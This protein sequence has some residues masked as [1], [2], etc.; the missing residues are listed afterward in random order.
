MRKVTV[1]AAVALGIGVVGAVAI[2]TRSQ[3]APRTARPNTVELDVVFSPFTPIATNNERDRDSLIALGDE[4]V[5]HD[6]LFNDGMHTGDQAGVCVIVATAPDV[7]AS[8][9]I[10]IRLPDGQLTGQF[11]NSPGPAPKTIAITGGTGDYRHT[12]GEGTLV[13]FGNGKGHLALHVEPAGD[14][15]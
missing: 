2:G 14:R 9:S 3:A 6:E 5:F 7:L 4:I 13:E 10:V 15:D 11:T 12:G 8:C 1:M